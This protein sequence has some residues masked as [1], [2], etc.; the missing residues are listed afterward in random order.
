MRNRSLYLSILRAAASPRRHVNDPILLQKVSAAREVE[1]R[2]YCLQKG[3]PMVTSRYRGGVGTC[4]LCSQAYFVL[5]LEALS[6]P[7]TATARMG[8]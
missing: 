5:V 8:D 6:A 3:N 7:E 4:P 2:M 1:L